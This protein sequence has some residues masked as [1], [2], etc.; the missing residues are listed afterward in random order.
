MDT[1]RGLEMLIVLL[2]LGVL[3]YGVYQLTCGLMRAEP[4]RDGESL[5]TC[6]DQQEEQEVESRPVTESPLPDVVEE[7]QLIGG[8]ELPMDF[9]VGQ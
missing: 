9:L 7:E 4:V 3:H 6:V 8:R 2:L 1:Q 5:E